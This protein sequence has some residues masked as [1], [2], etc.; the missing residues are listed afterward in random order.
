MTGQDLDYWR[1]LISYN[2][3]IRRE[4]LHEVQA[5]P[6]GSYLAIQKTMVKADVH[7]GETVWVN[8]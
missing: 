7:F 4:K 2:E 3:G 8:I 5:I 6:Y 1:T